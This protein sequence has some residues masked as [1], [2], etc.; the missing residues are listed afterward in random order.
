MKKKLLVLT[1]AVLTAL[2][3]MTCG[4]YANESGDP[5]QQDPPQ[6]VEP[7]QGD[8]QQGDPQLGD[9]D[10]NSTDPNNTDPNNTDPNNPDPNNPDPDNPDPDNPD[11]DN[12]QTEQPKPAPF[13]GW[14]SNHTKYLIKDVPVK[15]LKKL[16]GSWYFFNTK[17]GV[18][19]TGWR[20]INKKWY[21]FNT[22]SGKAFTGVHKIGKG[23]YFFDENTAKAKSKGFFKDKAGKEYYSTSAKGKLATGFQALTRGKK[24]VKNGYYF[25]KK[26]GAMAKNTVVGHLR[27]PKS[28][29]LHAAYYYG[30]KTLNKQGWTLKAAYKYA[31]KTKYQGR[32]Y[33]V[34]KK[35]ALK[36]EAY[37][38]KGF[39]KRKGNC[40]VMAAQFYVMAKLLG[41]DI[42]Q[43]YGKVGLPH[44]WTEIRQGGKTWVYDPN[45]RNETGRNGWKIWYGKKGTW[46]YHKKGKLNGFVKVGK[47][48]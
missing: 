2:A 5:P 38:I 6:Q 41:A 1:I 37:S 20:Q 29:R 36:S 31:Y 7:Q 4:A 34:S 11:P 14:N 33:R 9:P 46:R 19:V 17:T 3:W 28:G 13:T 30:I 15:G 43:V 39:T 23:L 10:P 45:F 42:R 8:P 27:I 44:S 12:P 26:T 47:F 22:K 35:T 25:S 48:K 32:W 16:D 24:K 21:F 18:R 40:Y